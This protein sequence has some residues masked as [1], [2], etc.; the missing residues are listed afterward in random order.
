MQPLPMNFVSTENT[1]QTECMPGRSPRLTIQQARWLQ[2]RFCPTLISVSTHAVSLVVTLLT[3]AVLAIANPLSGQKTVSGSGCALSNGPIR[4]VIY[5]QFDNVHFTRDNPNVPSDLEQMPHLLNFLEGNGT[6][7]ANHHTPL[8]SHTADDIIT[9]LTGVYPDRHGLA[10]ANS[11][12]FYNADG[13]VGFTSAFL[14][15]NDTISDPSQSYNLLTAT[16]KNAPAPWVPYTRAGCDFGAV[17]TANI[18]LENLFPDV[19]NVFGANSPEAQE[20]AKHPN[21][22]NKDFIGISVHCAAGGG[23][24]QGQAH[25]SPDLL[26]NEPGGYSGFQALYG[27]KYVL[28]KIAPH[29]LKDLNGNPIDG[30]PGFDG[31][32]PAVSLAYVAAMQ[33]AGIPVTYAYMA[34]AHEDHVAGLPYGP[35]EAGYVAQLQAYDQAF[36]TFFTRL[37]NDGITPSNTLFVITADEGDHFSGGPPSPANC[38]GIHTPCTYAQ[39]GEIDVNMTALL[40]SEGGITTP[41]DIHFDMAPSVYL[42]GD[43]GRT[44][45][46]VR[47]F[48]RASGPLTAVNPITGNTDN[49]TLYMA[50]PLELKTLHMITADKYRTPTFVLFG[51][52]NYFFL[53][54]GSTVLDSGFAWNHG[55]VAPE[56][57]TTWLGLVGPGLKNDGVDSQLWSDHTDIR[58][59]MMLLLG[60]TDDYGHDGRVLVEHINP[61][62]LPDELGEDVANFKLLADAYKQ[63]NAPVGSF[64]LTSLLVSTKALNSNDPQDQTYTFLESEIAALTK[65][66]DTLSKQIIGL[67]EGAAFHGGTITSAQAKQL[68]HE[69]KQLLQ[70]M[71]S[72][73]H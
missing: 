19:P 39:I 17:A 40:A 54:F 68:S 33:E 32:V 12:G 57:D 65:S 48:E 49:I 62:V 22:A 25:A 45:P 61:Q 70:Q 67:L 3:C 20:A 71:Q 37:A 34:D 41:F 73:T 11:Y 27:N 30:F 10:V 7:L 59:T 26:P 38:D 21:Q 8:I 63:I 24:C 28:D 15:W 4:H 60:L 66:R 23:A 13:S 18:E 31:I 55:G 64:G 46:T 72:L 29:G 50:D 47:A 58:P 9:S 69:A 14:Y 16:G 2:F 43:P 35:G 53:T 56:I 44:D 52:P 1:I 5:L 6:L 36:A 42:L 51:D